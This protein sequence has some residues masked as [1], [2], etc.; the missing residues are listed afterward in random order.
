[1]KSSIIKKIASSSI[2]AKEW[3]SQNFHFHRE[4]HKVVMQNVCTFICMKLYK[5][6]VQ[7]VRTLIC[8]TFS[9]FLFFS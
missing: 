6:V 5:I 2:T 7:F 4:F 9:P 3:P 1:M 8:M